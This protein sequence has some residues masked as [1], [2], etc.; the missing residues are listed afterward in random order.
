[1]GK[2][3]KERERE[4]EREACSAPMQEMGVE[5]CNGGPILGL[6]LGNWGNE[7]GRNHG[8]GWL[9]WL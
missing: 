7:G 4:K 2:K 1:M 3:E 8:S 6:M 5:I 9:T